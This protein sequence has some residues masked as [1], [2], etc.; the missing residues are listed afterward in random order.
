MP[1][2]FGQ[3]ADGTEVPIPIT[4]QG[5]VDTSASASGTFDLA[6]DGVVGA[7]TPTDAVLIGGGDGTNLRGARSFD[8]DTGAG[9]DYNIGFSL[10]LPAN[11]GSVAGGTSTNPLNVT[12]ALTDTQLRAT[13]VPVS[14]P[15]TDT[16]LRA[17][18]VPVS[19]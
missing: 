12:G 18:A 10:R 15:L 3:K 17:T 9:A 4:P 7:A 14:G 16:Q 11:G 2:M 6:S 19:G 8:L 5:K 1:M 13:A